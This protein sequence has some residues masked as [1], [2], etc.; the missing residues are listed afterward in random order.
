[1]FADSDVLSLHLDGRERNRRFVDEGLIR[2]MKPNV[3]F[4]NTSRGFVVDSSALAD[5]LRAH[6]QALA[7][8][9]VHDPEP[10]GSDYPLL[11]LSNARLYPHLASRTE[12]AMLNMSWVVR[13]VVAV[14]EGKEPEYPAA[15]PDR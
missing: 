11:G 5:F 2:R 4:I 7:M 10:F 6:V 13:D 9:D 12:A 8:L 3:V 14:L 1:M 15:S